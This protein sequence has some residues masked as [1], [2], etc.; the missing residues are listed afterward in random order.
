[1][2]RNKKRRVIETVAKIIKWCAKQITTKKY[3]SKL[4]GFV[5]G[6][7]ALGTAITGGNKVLC[8]CS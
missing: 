7:F 3:V 2:K 4:G 5:C 6:Q 8:A 1:M